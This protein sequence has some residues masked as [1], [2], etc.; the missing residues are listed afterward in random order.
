MKFIGA[1]LK[2]YWY[3]YIPLAFTMLIGIALNLSF[4][5]FISRITDA[6]IIQDSSQL[7]FMVY[8]GCT[9]LAILGL[10]AYTDT[11]L[12]AKVASMIRND[13]KKKTMTTLLQLKQPFYDKNHS[14]QL[15]TRLTND[16]SLVGDALGNTLIEL[17]KNPLLAIFSFIYLVSINWKLAII[18]LLI[19]PVTLAIAIVFGRAMRKLSNDLQ[20]QNGQTSSFLQDVLGS[21]ILFKTF[22]LENIFHKKFV[23]QAETIFE[24]ELKNGKMRGAL[25]STTQVV[26]NIAFLIAFILGAYFVSQG[27]MTVGSL[28]AFTQ[29]MNYLIMPFIAFSGIWGYFQYSMGAADRISEILDVLPEQLSAPKDAKH[30]QNSFNNLIMNQ[31]HFEYDNESV[32]QN[33]SLNIN[34]GEFVAIVGPSGSGKSTLFKLLLS[35]YPSSKGTI[36]VDGQSYENLSEEEI[37]SYFSM[38]P[39]EPYLFSGTILENIIY[40]NQ[41]ATEEELVQVAIHANAYEFITNLKDGFQTEVGERGSNLSGG[42]KQRIAIARAILRNA[43][44]LLLDE[45]TASLDN[46]SERLVQEAL[47]TMMIGKTTLVIAHR[48]STIQNAD[49]ILVMK[50]GQIVESGKHDELLRRQAHYFNLYNKSL[51]TAT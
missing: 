6:A 38:V 34:K 30:V 29:L 50:D 11:Y 19:S 3:L 20:N 2:Q 41:K 13:L 7:I 9:I 42:Q 39:Q 46:E 37:R 5:W 25:D 26:A 17:I 1:Y 8:A 22:A 47:N 49:R 35:L 28:V 33:L 43:P 27:D 45:A 10:N 14:G 21:S 51:S 15:V 44:I 4:A 24:L 18:C 16:N 36:S 31:V 40:G 48:L 23:K 12:K 32:I